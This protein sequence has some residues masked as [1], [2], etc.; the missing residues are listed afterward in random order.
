MCVC[1][2]ADCVLSIYH[3]GDAVL[4]EKRGHNELLFDD[5]GNS[6][7]EI[8]LKNRYA[9]ASVKQTNEDQLTNIELAG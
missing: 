9:T 6:D 8:S 5:F 2:H 3:S 4:I 7:I 1:F